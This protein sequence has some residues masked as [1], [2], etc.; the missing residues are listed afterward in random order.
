MGVPG[1][2][3]FA[4]SVYRADD[5]MDPEQAVSTGT[6]IMACEFE[7]GVVMGADSRTTTGSYVANRVSRKVSQ[8]HDR[9]FVCR[10]GSAADTQALTG[11]VQHYL[12]MH[13]IELGTLPTV[14]TAASLFQLLCYNNKD[15]LMAGMIIGGWDEKKGPDLYSIMLGGTMLPQKVYCSGS[16]SGYIQG[17]IDHMWRE[18]MSRAEGEEFVAKCIAHAMDRDGSSGGM[19]RIT[20]ITKEKV[21]E[22]TIPGDKLPY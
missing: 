13:A 20:T 19:I 6:T 12:G 14:K 1:P 9:I 17:L 22:K 18:N 11:F 15:N 21:E 4:G 2:D 3:Q 8:V 7:G 16:G 5:I 10:S